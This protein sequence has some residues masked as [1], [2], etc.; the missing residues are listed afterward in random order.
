[1][2][3]RSTIFGSE[4]TKEVRYAP[5][6]IKEHTFK[7]SMGFMGACTLGHFAWSITVP[8]NIMALGFVANWSRRCYQILTSCI[9]KIELHEDGEKVTIFTNLGKEFV[10]K[11]SD[12]KKL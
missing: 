12:I 6:L 3:S 1:M 10:V 9:N 5:W 4:D 2:N 7:H 11:I 8:C